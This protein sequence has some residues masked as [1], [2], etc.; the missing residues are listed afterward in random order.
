MRYV[1]H[2]GLLK[3]YG[4][5]SMSTHTMSKVKKGYMKHSLPLQSEYDLQCQVVE[6]LELLKLQHKVLVFTAIPNST[7][8]KSWSAKRRNTTMGLR[9]GLCDLVIVF[10]QGVLLFLELKREKKGYSVPHR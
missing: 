2:G 4:G 5:Y 9:P 1:K 10:S 7:Y 8:T 6:Y 3:D